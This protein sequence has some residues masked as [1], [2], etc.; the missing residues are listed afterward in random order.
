MTYHHLYVDFD[1]TGEF[2]IHFGDYDKNVVKQESIDVRESEGL[3]VK[4]VKIITTTDDVSPP[5]VL[6]GIGFAY[7]AIEGKRFLSN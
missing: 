2:A 7:N 6:S 5:L 1:K 4:H 3:Q